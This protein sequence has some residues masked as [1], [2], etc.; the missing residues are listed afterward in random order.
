MGPKAPK[1]RF[2]SIPLLLMNVEYTLYG[3]SKM[4]TVNPILTQSVIIPDLGLRD[5]METMPLLMWVHEVLIGF[6]SGKW[7]SCCSLQYKL[8]IH[9][10][11]CIYIYTY[12]CI[13]TYMDIPPIADHLKWHFNV[14]FGSRLLA[15]LSSAVSSELGGCTTPQQ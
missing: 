14:F 10:F 1:K 15:G 5:Y 2:T 3:T 6:L 7:S 12:I 4:N 11:I 13:Y 9:I 8:Y